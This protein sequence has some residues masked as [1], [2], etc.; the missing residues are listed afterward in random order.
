MSGK[1]QVMFLIVLGAAALFLLWLLREWRRSEPVP[2]RRSWREVSARD[3]AG[4]AGGDGGHACGHGGGHGG[5]GGDC[6]GDGGGH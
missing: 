1:G 5:H 4:V 2:R 3:Y 6:G